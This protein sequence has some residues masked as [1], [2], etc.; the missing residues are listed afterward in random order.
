M[1]SVNWSRSKMRQRMARQGSEVAIDNADLLKASKDDL[2]KMASTMLAAH[3]FPKKGKGKP[4]KTSQARDTRGKHFSRCSDSSLHSAQTSRS[5]IDRA[6]PPGL[7]IYA[8]GCCEPNPGPGGWGFVVYRDGV[9]IHSDCGGAANTTN[10]VMEMTGAMMALEW[11]L[12]N[13]HAHQA[14]LLCDSQYIV[15]GCN[16]WRHSWKQKGWRRG[17]PNAKPENSAIAN[18]SLWQ[19]IDQVLTLVPIKL[20]WV[21]GHAGIIGNERADELALIGRE[22]AIE[23]AQ[24]ADPNR[25]QLAYVA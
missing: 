7:V 19:L 13:D 9:E 6:V 21:K 4:A 3:P 15:N 11:L 23:A 12:G 10:N 24:A 2:R 1:S 16:D 8:D 14:R 5:P 25:Q 20:E 22:Q 17:G 18:L